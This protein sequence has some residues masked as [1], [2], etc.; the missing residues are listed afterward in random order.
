MIQ[1][2]STE[3]TEA[4]EEDGGWEEFFDYVFP[5]ETKSQKLKILDIA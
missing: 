1:P 2:S 4:A 3:E 5:E